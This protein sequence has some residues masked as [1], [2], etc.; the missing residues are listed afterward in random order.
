MP[1]TVMPPGFVQTLFSSVRNFPE[2]A[3]DWYDKIDS[4]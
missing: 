2:E 1:D 3:P 4:R